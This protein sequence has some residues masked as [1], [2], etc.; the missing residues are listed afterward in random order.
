MTI[1]GY[2]LPFLVGEGVGRYLWG[3]GWNFKHRCTVG[4][5]PTALARTHIRHGDTKKE[6]EK[7]DKEKTH[8]A[9]WDLDACNARTEALIF[10][11]PI[12]IESKGLCEEIDVIA[13]KIQTRSWR[14]NSTK[15]GT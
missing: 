8:A 3:A 2:N 15:D 9:V 12:T 11:R 14:S 7:T 1:Y 6:S 5:F 4:F 13:F 10:V